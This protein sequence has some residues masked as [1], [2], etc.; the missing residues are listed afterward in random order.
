MRAKHRSS[1][2]GIFHNTLQ[3]LTRDGGTFD[4]PKSLRTLRTPVRRRAAD[5]TETCKRRQ[6]NFGAFLEASDALFSKKTD[7]PCLCACFRTDPASPLWWI[8]H[9]CRHARQTRQALLHILSGLTR[10][11]IKVGM[12]SCPRTW[13]CRLVPVLDNEEPTSTK[14]QSRNWAL[15]YSLDGPSVRTL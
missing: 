11:R 10:S 15:M 12:C 5:L 6:V 1:N 9:C 4:S 2:T 8:E 7:A 14:K 13:K 3:L